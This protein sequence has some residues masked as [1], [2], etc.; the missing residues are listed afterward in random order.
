[1]GIGLIKANEGAND[2]VSVNSIWSLSC[3]WIKA[4]EALSVY[5]TRPSA[6]Q[7]GSCPTTYI[8]CISLEPFE[9]KAI[10]FVS[11]DDSLHNISGLARL[12]S[13][14]VLGTSKTH[15]FEPTLA[16][17]RIGAQRS[18]IQERFTTFCSV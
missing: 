7:V 6:F 10:P 18:K 17:S 11:S 14:I 13:R 16:E 9:D 2:R 4:A 1:M 8:V 3:S 15:Y 5:A 12:F